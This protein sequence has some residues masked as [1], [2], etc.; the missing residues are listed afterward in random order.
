MEHIHA[1]TFAFIESAKGFFRHGKPLCELVPFLAHALHEALPIDALG[2]VRLDGRGRVAEA[3]CWS[4]R[5]AERDGQVTHKAF[6]LAKHCHIL[7]NRSRH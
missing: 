1:A 6:S 5:A 2:V 4:E 3:A 7:C